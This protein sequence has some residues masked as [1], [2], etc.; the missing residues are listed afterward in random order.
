M[1]MSEPEPE[2]PADISGIEMEMR[3]QRLGRV[4]VTPFDASE[5]APT[6]DRDPG[7]SGLPFILVMVVALIIIMLLVMK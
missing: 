1:T 4:E 5:P 3:E 2:A 6:S 7:N